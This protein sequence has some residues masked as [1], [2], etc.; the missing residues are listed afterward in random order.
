MKIS[1]EIKVGFV[2]ILAIVLFIYGFYY[3]KGMNLLK[4]Q[5]YYY[6]VYPDVNGLVPN[7]IIQVNGYTI[8]KVAD[9][10]FHPKKPGYLVVQMQLH[11]KNFSIPKNSIARISSLDFLGTKGIELLMDT[12]IMKRIDRADNP[13]QYYHKPGDTLQNDVEISLKDEV[14]KQVAPLKAKAES[15]IS[16][17]EILVKTVQGIDI[18]QYQQSFG[19][20]ITSI[21]HSSKATE[22]IIIGNSDKISNVMSNLE[23]IS[24]NLKD[25]NENISRVIKN[26]S[27]ISDT[28]TKIEIVQTFKKVDKAMNDLSFVIERLNKGEGT[29]GKLL[30]D[31]SLYNNLE[32]ATKELDRL[33]EDMR[34]NPK[35]Y[36]HFSLF[37]KKEK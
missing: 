31:D 30:K 1:K 12:A 32:D 27:S 37:G 33:L 10:S 3:L 22:K 20:A 21:E 26:V 13:E 5:Q 14:N 23:T 15:L 9:I 36:V 17:I 25:N 16:E 19:R 8:G 2:T 28:L 18:E 6:V 7:N 34:L 35:R 29:A 24:A 11:A 4:N